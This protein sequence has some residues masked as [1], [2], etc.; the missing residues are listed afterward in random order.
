M[1]ANYW[2][3]KAL[4][5]ST[6]DAKKKAIRQE[7]H[8]QLADHDQ[9]LL[10][11]ADALVL[12]VLY[13]RFSFG[14]KRLRQFYDCFTREIRELRERY[15]LPESDDIWLCTHKLKDAGIDLE[16]WHREKV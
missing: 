9:K 1:K 2:K 5:A 3:K 7:I 10:T 12:W 6:S 11:E 14:P 4:S 16:Q 8:R 15:E 13:S